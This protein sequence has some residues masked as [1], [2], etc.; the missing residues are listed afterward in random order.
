MCK[1]VESLELVLDVRPFTSSQI[2]FSL[3]HFHT[4]PFQGK[5]YGRSTQRRLQTCGTTA[6]PLPGY[7]CGT[8]QGQSAGANSKQRPLGYHGDHKRGGASVPG[9]PACAQDI[10]NAPIGTALSCLCPAPFGSDSEAIGP[11]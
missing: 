6:V 8:A 3:T 2:F 11:G 10:S 9:V 4:P 7:L 5:L 1:G